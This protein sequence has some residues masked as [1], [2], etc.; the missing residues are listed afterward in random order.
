[1]ALAFGLSSDSPTIRHNIKEKGGPETHEHHQKARVLPI[2]VTQKNLGR[3]SR[4]FLIIWPPRSCHLITINLYY[5]D[6]MRLRVPKRLAKIHSNNVLIFQGYHQVQLSKPISKCL[7][8]QDF[9]SKF[10]CHDFA[11]NWYTGCHDNFNE[12]FFLIFQ[13]QWMHQGTEKKPNDLFA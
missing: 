1:M 12:T 4:T 10:K 13:T 6:A 2:V 11:K 3:V 7:I 8:F 9:I 5:Y